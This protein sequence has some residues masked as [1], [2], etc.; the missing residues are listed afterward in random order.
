MHGM[1][2]WIVTKPLCWSIR[3]GAVEYA[4][5]VTIFCSHFSHNQPHFSSHHL[6]NFQSLSILPTFLPTFAHSWVKNITFWRNL[7]FSKNGHNMMPFLNFTV[8]SLWKKVGDG[9]Y[10][11]DIGCFWVRDRAHGRACDRIL[12]IHSVSTKWCDGNFSF[13]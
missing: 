2:S 13:S 5:I 7:L 3:Y 8:C 10:K 11:F 4:F 6:L 1:R 9:H 12:S